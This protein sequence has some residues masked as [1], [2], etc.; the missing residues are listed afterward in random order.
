MSFGKTFF[1]P[2]KLENVKFCILKWAENIL[3]EELLENDD[4]SIVI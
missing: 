1:K 3:K 2:E 4:I